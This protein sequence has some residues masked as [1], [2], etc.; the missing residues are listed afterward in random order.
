M[1]ERD[2]G[3]AAGL[4][5]ILGVAVALLRPSG[6]PLL[7]E[8]GTPPNHNVAESAITASKEIASTYVIQ[9]AQNQNRVTAFGKEEVATINLCE[10]YYDSATCSLCWYTAWEFDKVDSEFVEAV[11][12]AFACGS[13]ELGRSFV[14]LGLVCGKF[15]PGAA[16]GVEA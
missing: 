16:Y 10:T 4:A 5:A 6:R 9:E 15:V 12:N 2:R 8:L 13:G 14:D 3:Q 1:D 7:L 11:Q